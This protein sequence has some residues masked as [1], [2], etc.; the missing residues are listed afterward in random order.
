MQLF[1]VLGGLGLGVRNYI[2]KMKDA[3]GTI[4]TINNDLQHLAL[5]IPQLKEALEMS[6]GTS[7]LSLPDA[8]VS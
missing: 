6:N 3:P 7:V 8:G 5:I 4:Q 2:K 1:D